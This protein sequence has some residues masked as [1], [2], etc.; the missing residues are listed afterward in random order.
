MENKNKTL[1]IV[2][3][4]AL[5]AGAVYFFVIRKKKL[6]SPDKP[7]SGGGV[8]SS[9]DGLDALRQK[10][11]DMTSEE[12]KENVA[13]KLAL[14]NEQELNDVISMFNI[15]KGYISAESFSAEQMQRFDQIK[16]KYMIFV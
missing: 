14:M 8:S 7:V 2:S 3:V 4:M 6:L 13:H 15:E 1:L 10:A 12:H 5:A 9:N 11:F 16:R